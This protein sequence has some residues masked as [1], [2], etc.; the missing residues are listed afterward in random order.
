[1]EVVAILTLPYLDR[2]RGDVYL[3]TKLC[4]VMPLSSKL[5]FAHGEGRPFNAVW[6]NKVSKT[7]ALSRCKGTGLCV[8]RFAGC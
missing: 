3:V 6:G 1:M 4:L 5:R 2:K 8:V 7:S